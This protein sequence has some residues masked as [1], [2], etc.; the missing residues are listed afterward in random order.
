MKNSTQLSRRTLVQNA[1]LAAAAGMLGLASGDSAHSQNGH[2]ATNSSEARA[3]ALIGDRFHNSDYIRVALDK[4]FKDLNI[5][6]DYTIRYD[7]I[8]GRGNQRI[9]EFGQWL[10]RSP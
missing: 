4:T 3:L 2:Q 7:Q 6:I 1:S 8:S 5:P 10:L 9:R